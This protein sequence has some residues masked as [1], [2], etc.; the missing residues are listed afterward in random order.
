[1]TIRVKTLSQQDSSPFQAFTFPLF[2][3]RFAWL[4]AGESSP[5]VAVG[6]LS[7]EDPAGLTLFEIDGSGQSAELL[8][9]FTAT[10]FRRQG[11]AS[12]MIRHG[13]AVLEQRG[14]KRV[15]AVYE[16][17]RPHS[18]SVHRLLAALHYPQPVVRAYVG[19]V[20]GHKLAEAAWLKPPRLPRCFEIFLWRD[21]K[22]EERR[23]IQESQERAPWFPS[24]LDPFRIE[25]FEP[26]NS[27]GLRFENEVVG[28]QINHRIAAD[29]IRYTALFVR[30]D[31]QATGVASA[32]LQ[33]SSL[34]HLNCED[35]SVDKAT[36]VVPAQQTGMVQFV[37]NRMQPFLSQLNESVETIKELGTTP[38]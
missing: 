19:R 18:E 5:L 4:A 10:P 2:Q 31:L 11:F 34:L 29:T 12:A 14:V 3:T 6:A 25:P 20:Q 33:T 28:W 22:P 26:L 38:V 21:L 27:V 30:Q 24:N 1:M 13:E 32:L 37:R 23:Q 36:F 7:I 35:A 15:K 8:S 17:S 16:Q 9:V